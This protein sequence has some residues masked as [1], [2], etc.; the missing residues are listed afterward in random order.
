[1]RVPFAVYVNSVILTLNARK[2]I[3]KVGN[4]MS[5]TVPLSALDK[6]LPALPMGTDSEAGLS[7]REGPMI[8]QD[9]LASRPEGT[10]DEPN[11]SSSSNDTSDEHTV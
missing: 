9:S 10:L 11:M 1:M 5:Y 6:R 8:G 3:Q 4:E 2:R 7:K